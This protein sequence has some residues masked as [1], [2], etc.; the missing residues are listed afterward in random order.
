MPEFIV[1]GA[2]SLIENFS[3]FLAT[4]VSSRCVFLPT[5]SCIKLADEALDELGIPGDVSVCA[6]C[7]APY[8]ERPVNLIPQEQRQRYKIQ[9]KF[10]KAVLAVIALIVLFAAVFSGLAIKIYQKERLLEEL[11]SV[12]LEIEPVVKQ[13]QEKLDKLRVIKSYISGGEAS[14]DVIYKL[15]EL[16]PQGIILV[17]FNYDD[18]TRAVRFNGRA[19][20]MSDV[21]KL[22]T[23]L[24]ES[25]AFSNVQTRSVVQ[26]QIADGELV[27]FQIRCNFNSNN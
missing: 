24:E 16:M 9:T 21:F 23:V 4:A 14:L 12:H 8:I 20:R 1:T 22:V 2:N 25:E 7:G 19:S 3:E 13:T 11:A 10:R 6:I 18:L 26:R 17:D 15:Y 5:L 27:D